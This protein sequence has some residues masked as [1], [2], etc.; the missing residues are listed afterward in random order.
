MGLSFPIQRIIIVLG[1]PRAPWPEP[2]ASLVENG[3]ASVQIARSMY[4]AASCLSAAADPAA[5]VPA[6][7]LLI[8]P[9][10]LLLRD[11]QA[12]RLILD[13]LPALIA[14]LPL[15]PG[16]SFCVSQA[17]A[18]G[19]RTWEQA[20]PE[21]QPAP[22]PAPAPAIP[23]VYDA[24]AILNAPPAE[25]DNHTAANTAE[26]PENPVTWDVPPRYDDSGVCPLVS[27]EEMHALL[28]TAE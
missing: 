27:E 23:V 28:G 3:Q 15:T 10:V 2:L 18:Y 21:L 22:A 6:P 12:A 17:A 7:V 9:Q 20:L 5:E 26:S 25:P 11:L 14:L 16:A 1:P 19:V 4:E 24:P 8:D 13:R